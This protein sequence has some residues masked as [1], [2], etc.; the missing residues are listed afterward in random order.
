MMRY[1]DDFVCCFQL[2]DDAHRFHA[3]LG[4]R[5]AKFHLT[6]SAEKT[7]LLRFTRFETKGGNTFNFL[8]FEYRWETSR[9]GN[10]L[11]RLFTSKDKYRQA[12]R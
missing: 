9:K 3:S 5:L 1:A 7:K 10:P 8:G 11:L 2:A 12:L 6:L 4:S